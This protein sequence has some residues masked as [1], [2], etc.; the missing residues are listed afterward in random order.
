MLSRSVLCFIGMSIAILA[1]FGAKWNFANS[2]STRADTKEIADIAVSFG[3]DDPQ[4]RYAAAVLYERTFEASDLAHSLAEF[5]SAVA[6]SPNNYLSWLALGGAKVRAGDIV[7]A[8]SAYRKA[9]ELAPKYADVQW[10]YGNTLLRNGNVE[11]GFEQIRKAAAGKQQYVVPAIVIAMTQWDGDIDKVR[12]TIG[13]T[14]SIN[15]S[16]ANYLVTNGK[17]AEAAA[18]WNKIPLSERSTTLKT[19]ADQFVNSLVG[20]KQFRFA[21]QIVRDTTP[22]IAAGPGEISDGGFEYGV[23]I[24]D[25]SFFEWKVPDGQEPQIAISNSQQKSGANSLNLAFNT[26]KTSEFRTVSQNV[27]VEPGRNYVFS[28]VYRSELKAANTLRWEIVDISEG[29]LLGKTDAFS[30]NADW[31]KIDARFTAPTGIDAV[32]VRLVRADCVS[33]LCPIAGRLWIDDVTLS[34][35]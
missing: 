9:F 22:N 27:T 7:G 25:A 30:A 20:A 23:K 1:V 21:A 14:S 8:E 17:F 24:K 34:A 5:E 2:V 26:N 16:L 35:L 6:N 18:T 32:V 15:A 28:A 31:T 33:V 12:E 19:T 10:A 13:D 3:P 29:K 4:T 11:T